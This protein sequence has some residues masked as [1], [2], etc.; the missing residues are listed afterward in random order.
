[1]LLNQDTISWGNL[2]VIIFTRPT[3]RPPERHSRAG[4]YGRAAPYL[5]NE[6][7]GYQTQT[8]KPLHPCNAIP[9][10]ITKTTQTSL[11]L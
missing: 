5:D 4:S 1:M 11:P 3:V 9:Q 10:F 7:F 6:H 2:L 8:T